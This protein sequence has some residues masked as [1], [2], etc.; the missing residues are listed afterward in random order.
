[1]RLL[2]RLLGQQPVLAAWFILVTA[3]FSANA[4]QDPIPDD[5]LLLDHQRCMNGCVPGFG[6]TTCRPLCDCTINEFKSKLTYDRYLDMQVQLSRNEVT[7]DMR[8]FLDGVAKFCTAE[9]DRL[10]IKVG[11]GEQG[12]GEDE[13]GDAEPDKPDTP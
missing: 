6:E 12:P 10:G 5:F 3:S 13:A 4:L 8:S 2:K 7:A 1:M 11:S 9:L